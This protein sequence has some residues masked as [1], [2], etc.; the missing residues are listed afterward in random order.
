VET[1]KL[2]NFLRIDKQTSGF[3]GQQINERGLVTKK[4]SGFN[5]M[6]SALIDAKNY[7][8]EGLS[9]LHACCLFLIDQL[10]DKHHVCGVDNL[11]TAARFFVRL[12]WK[13]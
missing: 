7:L 3:K 11:Y 4:K 8:D 9:S 10:K 5:V 13:K 12:R 2:E 6:Q 1:F